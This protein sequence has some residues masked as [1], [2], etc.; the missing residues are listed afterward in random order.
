MSD[1]LNKLG[2][3]S[4]A[5]GAGQTPAPRQNVQAAASA[6]DLDRGDD[7]LAKTVGKRSE[8]ATTTTAA[9]QTASAETVSPNTVSGTEEPTG[10]QDD[11]SKDSAL[12]EVKK[13]REE[14]KAYR[15]KYT[16]QLTK[17][18]EDQKAE[19]LRKD[20]EV[21]ALAVAKAELDRIKADQED[22]KRDL[23]EKVA[24]RESRIT[25]IQMKM[26]AQAKEAQE[27]LSKYEDIVQQFQAERA[28]EA[29]VY[30][31]RL[32]EELAKIPAKYKEIAGLIVK[33]AGDSRDAIVALGEAKIQGL[34]ED[35]TVVVNHTVPGANDGA[36]SSSERM[37]EQNRNRREKMS[38]SQKIGE[39]L[40]NI[41]SGTPNSAF[42][43]K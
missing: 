27:K 36:R 14:N 20:E 39:A 25:E 6:A 7:L 15:L 28:A 32:D 4:T 34:F 26:E 9:T 13:L 2:K 1:L 30:Q 19:L 33:G 5:E 40:K 42:R 29:Q 12:K 23:T 31:T 43:T 38:S 35:K 21:K 41:K 17:L 11:W 16:E 8:T 10:Q 3:P 37:E 22:K 24:H 18:Q